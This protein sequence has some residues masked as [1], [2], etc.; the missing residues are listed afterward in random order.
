MEAR[1]EAT[2]GEGVAIVLQL[3]RKGRTC[4]RSLPT[5][6]ST[7]QCNASKKTGIITNLLQENFEAQKTSLPSIP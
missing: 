1:G 4:Q 3:K 2:R 7:K 6:E 5:Q